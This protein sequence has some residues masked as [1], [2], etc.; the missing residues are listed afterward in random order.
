MFFLFPFFL[1]IP[2]VFEKLVPLPEHNYWT[3]N[4][5]NLYS[6]NKKKIYVVVQRRKQYYFLTN[7]DIIFFPI[8]FS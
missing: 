6:N 1:E 8:T 5:S 4:F 3:M 7:V 2:L